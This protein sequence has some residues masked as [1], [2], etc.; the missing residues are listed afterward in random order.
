MGKLLKP[1]LKWCREHGIARLVTFSDN[2][3]SDGHTYAA[4]GFT[5]DKELPPDY[6]YLYG[7]SRQHK[8]GFRLKRFRTAPE[9]E[10]REG[11]TEKQLA[12]L[13]CIPRVMGRRQKTMDNQHC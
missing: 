9:L 2:Q 3:V 6:K 5:L 7:D 1:A 10:W 11:L 8:F 12:E 4:L 13:N